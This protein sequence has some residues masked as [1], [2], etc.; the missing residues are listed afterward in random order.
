[1]LHVSQ[2]VKLPI[3]IA[4]GAIPLPGIV[5]PFILETHGDAIVAKGPKLLL[6]PIIQFLVP[7]AAQEF[8]DLGSTIEEFG[9]IAPF[10]IFGVGE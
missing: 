1:M 9:T 6:Q 7:L 10:G 5:M 4:V 8:D 2:F 3:F